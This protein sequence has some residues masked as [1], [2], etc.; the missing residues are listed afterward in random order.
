MAPHIMAHTALNRV[1]AC[2]PKL[3]DIRHYLSGAPGTPVLLECHPRRPSPP[4]G[5]GHRKPH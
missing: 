4:S 5:D 3:P 2:T 1:L